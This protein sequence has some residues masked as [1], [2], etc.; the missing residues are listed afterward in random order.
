M[1]SFLLIEG[2]FLPPGIEDFSSS[3]PK[4][5]P[6]HMRYLKIMLFFVRVPV[7]SV[8]TNL[9]WPKFSL[10]EVLFAEVKHL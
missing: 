6:L 8:K 1:V 4:S 9:I 3:S 5:Y 10:T 2:F 7:L